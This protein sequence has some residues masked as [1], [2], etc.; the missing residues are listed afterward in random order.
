MDCSSGTLDAGNFKVHSRLVQIVHEGIVG[1][2]LPVSAATA[3]LSFALGFTKFILELAYEEQSP[4]IFSDTLRVHSVLRTSSQRHSFSRLER[5]RIPLSGFV[6]CGR[7]IIQA[8]DRGDAVWKVR[9]AIVPI[10]RF[11]PEGDDEA[12]TSGA[13]NKRLYAKRFQL[14]KSIQDSPWFQ[15]VFQQCILYSGVADETSEAIIAAL[16]AFAGLAVLGEDRTGVQATRPNTLLPKRPVGHHENL[17]RSVSLLVAFA[18]IDE[19]MIILPRRALLSEFDLN[20]DHSPDDSINISKPLHPS[21]PVLKR[22]GEALA[23]GPRKRQRT[24]TI[25]VS[26]LPKTLWFRKKDSTMVVS[27]EAGIAWRPGFV[28]NDRLTAYLKGIQDDD[29]KSE[30]WPKDAYPAFQP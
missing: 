29:S 18:Q 1:G 8:A 13:A 12:I 6:D 25:E 24:A 21:S 26:K 5:V 3:L 22:A 4:G 23:P 17:V 16:S 7:G 28:P 27:T 11:R 2:A 14:R 9:V 30:C 20:D 10:Q 15:M 19:T